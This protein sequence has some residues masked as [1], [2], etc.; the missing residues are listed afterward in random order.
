MK[1][2]ITDWMIFWT[3]IQT[4]NKFDVNGCMLEFGCAPWY[5][6]CLNGREF[7]YI[8]HHAQQTERD[9][10][11]HA[12]TNCLGAA[13]KVVIKI[14]ILRC[15]LHAISDWIVPFPSKRRFPPLL[16]SREYA[17][18][19]LLTLE[20]LIHFSSWLDELWILSGLNSNSYM[21]NINVWTIEYTD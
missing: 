18:L 1:H 17:H 13:Q 9:T 16:S 21:A 6:P 14:W 4:L 20:P 5:Y 2:W 11:S 19:K 3:N 8:L 12:R 15:A 10:G 7:V